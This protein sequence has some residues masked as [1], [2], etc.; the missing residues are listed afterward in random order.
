MSTARRAERAKH[1]RRGIEFRRV[2]SEPA[3]CKVNVRNRVRVVVLGTLPIVNRGDN[4]THCGEGLVEKGVFISTNVLA[5]PSPAMDIEDCGER[6]WPL[7]L[8]DGCLERLPIYPQVVD[9][10]RME[11]N[12][13][14]RQMLLGGRLATPGQN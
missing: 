12:R 8:V 1:L 4:H 11:S 9:I 2:G 14:A 7:W 6:A 10:L 3:E 5:R 13:L